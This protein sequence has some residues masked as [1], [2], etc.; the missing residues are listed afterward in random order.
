MESITKGIVRETFH[1]EAVNLVVEKNLVKI[2]KVYNHFCNYNNHKKEGNNNS[3]KGGS[4]RKIDTISLDNLEVL[5]T[6]C[7]YFN[8]NDESSISD[9]D[10]EIEFYNCQWMKS[11]EEVDPQ[12]CFPE[13][14][15]TEFLESFCRLSLYHFRMKDGIDSDKMVDGI[16]TLVSL[17]NKL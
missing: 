16:H 10:I 3:N 12:G 14:V 2:L 15:F 9:K 13:L 7:G 8:R 11:G 6:M 17:Y 1:S 5:L 4:E